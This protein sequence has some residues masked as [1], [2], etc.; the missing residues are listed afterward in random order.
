MY[1]W[2][3]VQ[4]EQQPDKTAVVY[5]DQHL[6]FKS[7][8]K[9]ALKLSRHLKRLDR[10]RLGLYIGNTLEAVVLV[11][12][13]MIAGI[14]IVLINTRLTAR[15][16]TVQLGDIDVDTVITT[17]PL[18]LEGHRLYDLT[19]L[20]ELEPLSY[21]VDPPTGGTTLSIMFTSGTTGRAK[22]VPQSYR[23]H[24]TS[25]KGCEQRFGYGHASIWMNVNPIYHISGFSI[26]MRSVIAGCPMV[27]VGKF[28]EAR[29][30]QK[31]VEYG[32]THTSMV[33]IM[34]K[35]LMAHP[36]PDHN[37][38]GVLLG[39]AGV[40]REVLKEALSKGLPVY[41]SFGMTETC[42]QIVSIGPGDP[43]ILEG[44]AGRALDNVEVAIDH[45]NDGEILVKG[46][47]V[48][49][50]YL[51]ADIEITE[52]F[53]RTGDM[54]YLDEEGYLYIL[55]RRKDLIISGGE[56]IYPK[57]IEDAANAYEKVANSAVVKR[58]DDEWGEVPVLMIEAVPGE[59]I[60]E[61]TLI[62]HLKARLARYKLPKDIKVVE[63]IIMTSTGKVSRGQ[64]QQFYDQSESRKQ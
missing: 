27:L 35:R 52:K 29:I 42:S 18:E 15:E 43:K 6:S 47:P 1:E 36:I 3:K 9:E 34:L 53:F 46:G 7:L 60:D 23:N 17:K 24:F 51:N 62:L 30:W 58:Q 20:Y 45:A 54:G 64:N 44:T 8:Y 49:G 50:H 2:L 22:A 32:V 21:N 31:V 57:E 11:H 40:T 41:N 19:D 59:T 13:S 61:R 28:D 39:G 63:N 38:E 5:E 10:N 26:L 4:A 37:L 25:A 16:I 14:E 33:P 48:I 55:D 12:A 56:N